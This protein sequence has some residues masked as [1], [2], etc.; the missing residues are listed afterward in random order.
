MRHHSQAVSGRLQEMRG[1]SVSRGRNPEVAGN[2]PVCSS[3][4]ASVQ[5][6]GVVGHGPLPGPVTIGRIVKDR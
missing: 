3:R 2:G 4:L 5:S 1:K 6:R